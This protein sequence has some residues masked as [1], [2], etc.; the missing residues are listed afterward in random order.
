MALVKSSKNEEAEELR[1]LW[2]SDIS[3]RAAGPSLTITS[4][5]EIRHLSSGVQ[6]LASQGAKADEPCYD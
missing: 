5:T 3:E 6:G 2:A 1:N 4:A